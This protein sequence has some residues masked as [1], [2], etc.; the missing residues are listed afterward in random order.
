MPVALFV[1]F[2]LAVVRV[3]EPALRRQF[4]ANYGAYCQR[5]PRWLPRLE[6]NY[7]G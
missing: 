3:E 1:Y 4:G 2:H 6:G 7:D 5:V